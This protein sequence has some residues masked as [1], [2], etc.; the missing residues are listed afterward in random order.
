MGQRLR[1]L[2]AL[3]LAACLLATSAPAGAQ[4]SGDRTG[5]AFCM[6]RLGELRTDAGFTGPGQYFR[7][8][9][10]RLRVLRFQ[11]EVGPEE[12]ARLAQALRTA[13]AVDEVWLHSPGGVAVQGIAM[14]RALRRARVA[15]RVPN[16]AMCFSACAIA[17]VGGEV[18][19]VDPQGCYGNHMFSAWSDPERARAMAEAVARLAAAGAAGQ[20]AARI[21]EFMMAQ[22]QANARLSRDTARYYQEM[23][24]SIELMVPVFETSFDGRY[25]PDRRQLRRFNVENVR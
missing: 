15:V 17:F 2:L 20:A 5:Q 16:G 19:E 23:G 21:Q 9:H 18:R 1:A 10:G 4:P 11:G 6:A 12:G 14:G 3:A 8:T 22:E 24:I 7:E 13:G 25:F